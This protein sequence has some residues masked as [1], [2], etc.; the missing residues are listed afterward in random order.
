MRQNGKVEF[1]LSACL[2]ASDSGSEGACPSVHMCLVCVPFSTLAT[3]AHQAWFSTLSKA[4]HK[5]PPH[6]QD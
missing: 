1:I 4:T 5:L 2:C 6:Q 3:T